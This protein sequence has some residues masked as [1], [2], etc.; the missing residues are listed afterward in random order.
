MA[1]QEKVLTR[2]GRAASQGAAAGRGPRSSRKLPS[3]SLSC[4]ACVEIV[5]LPPPAAPAQ[6]H[7]AEICILHCHAD[8]KSQ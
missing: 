5:E 4:R 1:I 3:G 7:A 8:M 6:V 2:A